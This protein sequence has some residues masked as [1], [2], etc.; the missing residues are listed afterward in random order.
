MIAELKKRVEA[1]NFDPEI[2]SYKHKLL[3]DKEC[4][5][6]LCIGNQYLYI[7]DLVNQETA[8][9]SSSVKNVLGY[10]L[11]KFYDDMYFLHEIIHPD[12]QLLIVKATRKCIDLI[13][14]KQHSKPFANI[15][16]M[17]YRVKKAN[18]NYIRILRQIGVFIN[19]REGNMAYSFGICTDISEIK[20][21]NKIEFSMTGPDT[22]LF[23]FPDDELKQ[24]GNIFTKREK[25][26]LQL[27]IQGKTSN[28]IAGL[29]FISPLTVISHRNNMMEKTGVKNIAELIAHAIEKGLYR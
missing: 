16:S 26:V 28:K 15:F 24:E 23:D 12:D 22:D 2:E 9:I 11:E 10:E 7:I 1:L 25:E 6:Y 21:V 3:N 19:D 20:K 5:K 17:D 13:S 27:L 29:L 4:E 8:C 14:K 18:G